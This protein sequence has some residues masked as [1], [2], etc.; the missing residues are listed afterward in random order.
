MRVARRVV[1]PEGTH[2]LAVGKVK[3]AVQVRTRKVWDAWAA[4]QS[5]LLRW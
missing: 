5:E 4:Q 1:R 3:R 2:V